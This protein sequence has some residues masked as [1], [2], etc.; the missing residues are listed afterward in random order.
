M[1]CPYCDE[2][3][4]RPEMHGHLTDDHPDKVVTETSW[5]RRF[6]ELQCPECDE[7]HRTEVKPRNT[8]PTFLEEHYRAIR[9]VAFDMFLYHWQDHHD[10]ETKNE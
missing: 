8:D 2:S 4:P 3:G 9:L 7:S 10:Q 1:R 5:G 6:M